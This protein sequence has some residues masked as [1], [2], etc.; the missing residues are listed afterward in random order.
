M[1]Y[2]EIRELC[3]LVDYTDNGSI[4][5][6]T[7]TDGEVNYI[8]LWFSSNTTDM[9]STIYEHGSNYTKEL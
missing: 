1:Q 5:Y 8:C 7:W 2:T 3:K 6:E 9:P 4:S